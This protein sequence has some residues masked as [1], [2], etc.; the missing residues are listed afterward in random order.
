MESYFFEL[1]DKGGPL[2][3]A[4]LA[5]SIIALAIV[6]DRSLF[7]LRIRLHFTSFLG[8]LVSLLSRRRF[9][10]ALEL[11]RKSRSPS[12]IIARSYLENLDIKPALRE[13]ILSRVGSQQVERVGARLRT[14][15]SIAHIAPL[16]GLFGTVLGMIRAFRVIEELKGQADAAALA[17]GIWEA[18]ITTAA[19]LVVAIPALLAYHA[20]EALTDRTSSRMSQVVSIFNETLAIE[21]AARPVAH[22]SAPGA[23]EGGGYVTL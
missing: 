5:C 23:E 9:E 2:M 15:G 22:T 11:A 8:E 10:H 6:L 18:L 14:L 7:F 21:P 17:G 12:A 4:I 3:W 19:G 16:L 13:D 20:F 1:M